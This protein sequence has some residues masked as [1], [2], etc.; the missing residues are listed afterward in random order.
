M[1]LGIKLKD[2]LNNKITSD[3][4]KYKFIRKMK[5]KYKVSGFKNWSIKGL[6]LE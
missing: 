4:I 2:D 1:Q 3:K 6:H 5:Q